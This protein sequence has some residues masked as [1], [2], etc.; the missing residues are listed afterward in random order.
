MEK[1]QLTG[2]DCKI[3]VRECHIEEISGGCCEHWKR[4]QPHLNMTKISVRDIDAKPVEAKEKRM[5]FFQSWVEQEGS[6]ATYF[7]LIEALQTIKCK[8]DAEFVCSLLQKQLKLDTDPKV[9]DS[10]S[11][12]QVD[13][14]EKL[15]QKQLKVSETS[16]SDPKAM[17][18]PSS[19]PVCA[20]KF[21]PNNGDCVPAVLDSS[22]H[23]QVKS[24]VRDQ[25]DSAEGNYIS[26]H[27]LTACSHI[28]SHFR[29]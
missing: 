9:M 15:Q 24:S 1:F 17:N 5:E 28:F 18:P 27:V 12:E 10:P 3:K 23:G 11:C 19:E 7:K 29:H 2:V 22:P 4:L 6:D 16:D 21:D 26:T 14:A 8:E 13:S 25:R 20:E